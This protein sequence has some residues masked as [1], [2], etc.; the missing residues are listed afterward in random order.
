MTLTED[1]VGALAFT[2]YVDGKEM[3]IV[4]KDE[5]MEY[6]HGWE[7]IIPGLEKALDGKAAGDKFDVTVQPEDAYG[8]YD[9][10]AFVEVDIEEFDAEGDEKPEVG[11]EVEMLDEDGDIIEGRITEVNDTTVI[12]D[13]NHELAGKAVRYVGEIVSIRDATEEELEWGFPESL[14]SE[15]FD[16]DEFELAF[17][18]DED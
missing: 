1:K 17:E 13:I 10:E 9:D 6:L 8:E 11:L 15:M 7:N 18:D 2:I 3:D 4:E 12:V 16:E 5:P 14:L